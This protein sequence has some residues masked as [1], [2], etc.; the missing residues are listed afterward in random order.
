M[1]LPIKTPDSSF[2]SNAHLRELK[3]WTMLSTDIQPEAFRT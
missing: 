1:P 2:L 3:K